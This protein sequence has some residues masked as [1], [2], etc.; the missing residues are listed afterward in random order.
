MPARKVVLCFGILIFCLLGSGLGLFCISQVEAA[1]PVYH[2]ALSTQTPTPKFTPNSGATDFPAGTQFI[3]Y[4]VQ[5]GDSIYLI[6]QKM[7]GQGS[8]YPLILS[9][10]NINENTRLPVGI[11]LKIPLLSTPTAT[12]TLLPTPTA[13]FALPSATPVVPSPTP[14]TNGFNDT[15]AIMKMVTAFAMSTLI[16]SSGVCL[17]FAFVVY[18]SSRRIARKQR[19]A[20]RVRPPLVR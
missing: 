20:R 17:F 6:A 10:N 4:T 2:I 18:S 11:I 8:K 19:M 13:T 12:S 14:S 1:P 9:A 7:Y 16:G 3:T 5:A 15:S